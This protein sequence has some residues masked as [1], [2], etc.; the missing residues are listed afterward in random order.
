[1]RFSA[2]LIAVVWVAREKASMARNDP[3]ALLTQAH[4]PG[5]RDRKW[6]VGRSALPH[7]S[8]VSLGK[9]LAL[10]GEERRFKYMVLLKV[11]SL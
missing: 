8:C 6:Q 4:E 2:T 11:L 1:M 7:T 9:S 10:S 5:L 3:G